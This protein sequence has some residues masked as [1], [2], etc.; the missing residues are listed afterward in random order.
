MPLVWPKTNKT[1]QKTK[2]VK[3]SSGKKENDI[4]LKINIHKERK[5]IKEIISKSKIFFSY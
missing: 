2:Y 1:K 3:R 5:G 4:D